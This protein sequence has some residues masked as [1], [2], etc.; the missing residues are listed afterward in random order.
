ML[1]WRSCAILTLCVWLIPC[2]VQGIK[3]PTNESP[4]EFDVKRS[5]F[6]G[7]FHLCWRA[8][9]GKV[10]LNDIGISD[11]EIIRGNPCVV[12]DFDGNGYLDFGFPGRSR[13][14][15]EVFKVLFYLKDRIIFTEL[16]QG[17]GYFLYKATDRKGEFGEPTSKTDG[18]YI[19]GE[20]GSTF[21]FLFNPKSRKFESSEHA[22]EHN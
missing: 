18:L 20:G 10:P 1:D 13:S 6:V 16:L 22:S 14:N 3:Q 19:P 12:G 5:Q 11:Q 15:Q 9:S 2:N 17:H 4:I 8:G 21:V 7:E